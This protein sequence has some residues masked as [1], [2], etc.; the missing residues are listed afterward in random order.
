MTDISGDPLHTLTRAGSPRAL[1]QRSLFRI[2]DSGEMRDDLASRNEVKYSLFGADAGKLRSLLEVNLQRQVHNDEVSEVRSIYFDDQRLSCGHANVDGLANRRK[3]RIRWYDSL[4]PGR[5]FFIETK[6]RRNRLTGKRRLQI[7]SDRPL[8]ELSYPQI[9][10]EFT[11]VLSD[12]DVAQ[13]WRFPDPVMVVEYRRE[14]FVSRD[15][16]VRLTLDCDLKI[17]NQMGRCSISMRFGEACPGF[18]VLEAKVAPGG[19]SVLR[20]LLHPFSARVGSS[21]KYVQGC[22]A[23]GLISESE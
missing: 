8:S 13:V 10:G 2:V 6:W 18:L 21:S 15:G 16:K 22:R 14:H 11:R 5:D 9:R 12:E 23:L 1:S 19:D 17:Y 4:Q 7:Y 3:L 20:R